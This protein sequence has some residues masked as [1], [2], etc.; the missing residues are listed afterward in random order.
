MDTDTII[1]RYIIRD[2]DNPDK[3]I[4]V[5]TAE[6][7]AK[8][9]ALLRWKWPED[10]R[11]KIAMIFETE[12]DSPDIAAY[13]REERASAVV[14]RDLGAEYRKPIEGERKRYLICP[15]CFGE[16]RTILLFRQL[17]PAIT[18]YIYFKT[19]VKYQIHYEPLRFSEYQRVTLSVS[20]PELSD[21]KTILSDGLW[22]GLYDHHRLLCRYPLDEAFISGKLFFYILKGQHIALM[23]H[24]AY[25]PRL[26]LEKGVDGHG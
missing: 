24:D 26:E 1:G 4:K 19:R 11:I 10:S 16:N 13:I 3:A 25:T 2:T 20:L 21:A 17:N 15:A 23:T 22:Y 7:D 5:L 12:D 6:A 18:G 14:T 8:N 9:N